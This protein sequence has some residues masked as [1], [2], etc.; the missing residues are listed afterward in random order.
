MGIASDLLKR[1]PLTVEKEE[2]SGAQNTLKYIMAS[3][4]WESLCENLKGE[5][6][7]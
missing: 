6:G 1:L 5:H 7:A 4:I 2:S 3:P